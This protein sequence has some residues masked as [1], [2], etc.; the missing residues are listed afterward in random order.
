MLAPLENL[1]A[2]NMSPSQTTRRPTL[3]TVD[4]FATLFHPKLSIATQYAQTILSVFP[5]SSFPSP[6]YPSSSSP[7]ELQS[8]L[9]AKLKPAFRTQFKSI[10]QEWPNYGFAEKIGYERWWG[11]LIRRIVSETD[12]QIHDCAILDKLTS[13]LLSRFEGPEGYELYPDVLPFFSKISEQRMKQQSKSPLIVGV[14]CNSDDR[15]KKI[16]SNLGLSV[17][18]N[19][20]ILEPENPPDIDFVLT[21][22]AAGAEKPDPRIFEQATQIARIK[23]GLQPSEKLLRM[24]VGDDFGKDCVGA[25]D[26]EWEASVF[27]DRGVDDGLMRTSSERIGKIDIGHNNRTASSLSQVVDMLQ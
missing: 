3:L 9:E 25:E 22:Y 11:E 19:D 18:S 2:L 21:S 13:T 4:A 16:L 26:A 27:L 15:V 23:C 12:V 1:E 7:S 20:A 10:S 14:I 5:R 6:P 8:A 24:H 17:S